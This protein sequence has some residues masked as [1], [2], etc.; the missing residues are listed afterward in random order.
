[1]ADISIRPFAEGDLL[2]VAA[3]LGELGY[4]TTLEQM[5]ARIDADRTATPTT[6]PSSPWRTV[7]SSA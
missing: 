4:P 6:P 5:R 3:L 1:M 7:A 2:A